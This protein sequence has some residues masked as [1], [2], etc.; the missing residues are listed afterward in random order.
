MTSVWAV[1]WAIVGA[2]IDF[3]HWIP[4]RMT[5]RVTW[6]MFVAIAILLAMAGDFHW[7]PNFD[8]VRAFVWAFGKPTSW[9]Y[10]G[11][12]QHEGT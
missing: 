3:R 1:L 6:G 12:I 8:L 4:H 11:T 10:I 9:L 2:V 7:W 5:E